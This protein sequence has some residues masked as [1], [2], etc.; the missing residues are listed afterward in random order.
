MTIVEFKPKEKFV[1]AE[2]L[3]D[4]TLKKLTDQVYLTNSVALD[5]VL[6]LISNQRISVETR[7]G[8]VQLLCQRIL[9]AEAALRGCLQQKQ[10]DLLC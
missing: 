5:K 1:K 3:E 6:Y 8:R 7:L 2:S 10:D 4:K 9:R